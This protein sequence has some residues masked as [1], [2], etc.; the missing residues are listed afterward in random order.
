[1]GIKQAE[2]EERRKMMARRSPPSAAP[3]PARVGRESVR[4]RARRGRLDGASHEVIFLLWVELLLDRLHFG[5]C[6]RRPR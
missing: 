1:M 5:T 3:Q 6:T 2:A 4:R